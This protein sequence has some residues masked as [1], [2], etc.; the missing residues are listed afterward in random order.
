M[1]EAIKQEP[2]AA[3]GPAIRPR[4]G[5]AH[6]QCSQPL[7]Q[8]K[9]LNGR[10]LLSPGRVGTPS[11]FSP[12]TSRAPYHPC[13]SCRAA[14]PGTCRPC[15]A[16]STHDPGR[17]ARP[18][19]AP[20]PEASRTPTTLSVTNPGRKSSL[21]PVCPLRATRGREPQE[22]R[23]ASRVSHPV[24]FAR[25]FDTICP[26]CWPRPMLGV[27][28]NR[29]TRT[30]HILYI[31]HNEPTSIVLLRAGLTTPERRL[32]TGNRE[33][34]FSFLVHRRLIPGG[35]GPAGPGRGVTSAEAHFRHEWPSER[36]NADR[37]EANAT[38]D[39]RLQMRSRE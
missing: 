37:N 38:G 32:F 12:L 39:C 8:V 36:T 35:A 6:T 15:P 13:G 16:P 4:L 33:V 27:V 28:H 2:I 30:Q 3:R 25:S 7:Q 18:R 1:P 19:S 31:P 20:N 24:P 14:W 9:G 21:P 34:V 11:A 23:S 26:I 29:P 10:H 5:D 17:P 22:Y